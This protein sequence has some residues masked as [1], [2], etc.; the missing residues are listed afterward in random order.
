MAVLPLKAPAPLAG[1]FSI[2]M[3]TLLTIDRK[4]TLHAEPRGASL[5]LLAGGMV[6]TLLDTDDDFKWKQGNM[7]EFLHVR[8]AGIEGYV[9]AR[10]VKLAPEPVHDWRSRLTDSQR[11]VLSLAKADE[12]A[13][14]QETLLAMAGLLDGE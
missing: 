12:L 9:N 14:L 8:V 4:Q 13:E 11:S 1:A 3:P 5:A 10:Y 7:H 2:P 6:F